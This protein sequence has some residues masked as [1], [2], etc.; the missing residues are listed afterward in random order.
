MKTPLVL[1]TDVMSIIIDD[2]Q[3]TIGIIIIMKEKWPGLTIDHWNWIPDLTDYWKY[4]WPVLR[5]RLLLLIVVC[6]WKQCV[7]WRSPLLID[8]YWFNIIGY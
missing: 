5:T 2:D 7:D 8:Y 1:L 6:E 3:M 4:Y